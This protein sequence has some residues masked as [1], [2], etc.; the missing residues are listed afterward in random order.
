MITFYGIESLCSLYVVLVYSSFDVHRHVS[1]EDCTSRVNGGF[2]PVNNQVYA[3]FI[4]LE[5][6]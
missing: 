1:C 2:D 6:V 5:C 3:I 4:K